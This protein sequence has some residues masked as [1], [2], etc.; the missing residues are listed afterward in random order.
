MGKLNQK[1]QRRIAQNRNITLKQANAIVVAHLGYSIIVEKEK[2]LLQCDW[3]QQLGNIAINDR[4]LIHEENAQHGIIEAIAPRK[5]TL[6]KTQNRQEKP[7]ASHLDQLLIMIAIEPKWQTDLIDRQIIAAQKAEIDCAIFCNK[8]DLITEKEQHEIQK[9]L[10]IYQQLGHKLFFGSIQE[11]QNLTPLKNWLKN[12]QTIIIGQSGIGKSS[13]IKSLIPDVDIWIQS[14]SE[15]SGH[16]K[17]TTTNL[18]RYPLNNGCIIDTP[19]IRGF[20]LN[21]LET[22]DIHLGFPEI[23]QKS[24][25]CKY[26]NCQH[27]NEPNCAVRQALKDGHIEKE[28]YRSLQQ[29]LKEKQNT[30]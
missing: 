16:G 3:R 15:A 17:H 20:S 24:A 28:R 22:K 12:K 8:I 27:Q 11:N 29:L 2:R 26:H 6:Y 9:K 7:I 18:K 25:H 5:N 19:G 21:H 10:E 23:L 1:Q 4:V 30:I 13:L 14:I